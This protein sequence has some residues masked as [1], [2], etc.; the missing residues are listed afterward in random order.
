MKWCLLLLLTS[1]FTFT[2]CTITNL[3]VVKTG[4]FEDDLHKLSDAYEVVD[5]MERG[6]A[7]FAQVEEVFGTNFDRASNVERIPGPMAFRRIYGDNVFYGA[8]IDEKK[9]D[10]LLHETKQYKAFLIPHKDVATYTDRWYFSTKE[11]LKQ[12]DDLL[13]LIMFKNNKL[14]YA[15]YKYVKIDSKESTHAFAQGLIDIIKE[16]LAPTDA[17][18]DFMDQIRK[19]FEK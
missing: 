14:F 19:E 9:R 8:G 3:S 10:E 1:S 2:G 13:I 5:K 11:T 15:D 4:L 16:F 7:T 12:G 18:Y 6:K 17:L